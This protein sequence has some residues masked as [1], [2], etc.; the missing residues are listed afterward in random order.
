MIV[1][2]VVLF[3][4]IVFF[5]SSFTAYAQ[6]NN[7]VV[8]IPLFGETT[9]GDIS[10][11]VTVAAQGG[12]FTSP[13][14][15]M[16]SITNATE[17]N[18]YLIVIAPGTYEINQTLEV[19]PHVSITGSGQS[20]TTIRQVN[21]TVT[22][23][24]RLLDTS[25][26]NAI[27]KPH[28]SNFH[29]EARSG[30]AN[31][32][33]LDTQFA[34]VLLTNLQ[35]TATS[36]SGLNIGIDLFSGSIERVDNVTIFVS[37]GIVTNGIRSSLDA[38][39]ELTNVN[40]FAGGATQGN[41]GVISG[42]SKIDVRNSEITV[43]TDSGNAFGIYYT[44]QNFQLQNEP[45]AEIVNTKIVAS[46][47]SGN[48]ISNAVRLSDGASVIVRRSSLNGAS[49]SI[50]GGVDSSTIVSASTLIGDVISGGD[51]SCVSSDNGN[52]VELSPSCD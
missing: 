42:F 40:I 26:S 27:V 5:A 3:C 44:F 52:G 49:E 18:P 1:R 8:V 51:V 46:S 32:I 23:S 35:L 12:D 13:I 11:V 37:G 48:A 2:C 29:I 39:T 47:L 45:I 25:N 19:K 31:C 6:N 33:A 10:N 7:R 24:L 21:P 41:F 9:S 4:S 50:A 22:T 17:E 43:R 16:N 34:N 38:F 36:C 28:L 30:G 15:A 20:I 14:S